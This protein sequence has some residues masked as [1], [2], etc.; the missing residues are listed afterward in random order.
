HSLT[1]TVVYGEGRGAAW[2]DGRVSQLHCGLDVL[3]KVVAPTDDEG[4]LHAAGDDQLSD[5]HQPQV[6]G[7]QVGP[8][9][10]AGGGVE[11]RLRELLLAPVA[12]GHV[13]SAQ[14][15]L[16]QLAVTAH[17]VGFRVYDFE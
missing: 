3:G 15:N 14:P 8:L 4:V 13:G 5:D 1:M 7:A 16:T 12:P 9:A 11:A 10:G 6:A 2:A 17:A